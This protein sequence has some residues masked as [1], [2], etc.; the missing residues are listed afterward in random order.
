MLTL[1]VF[2]IYPQAILLFIS[3][4][5][6]WTSHQFEASVSWVSLLQY[7]YIQP[8][9]VHLA[10]NILLFHVQIKYDQGTI[11]DQW[12]INSGWI[13]KELPNKKEDIHNNLTWCDK[14]FSKLTLKIN[15]GIIPFLF[16][17]SDTK[18]DI[19]RL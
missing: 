11:T 6:Q 17:M 16:L 5:N 10:N 12:K 15:H 13:E 1:S 19:L 8:K 4:I 7:I 3:I 18:N 2:Q 14:H 9:G